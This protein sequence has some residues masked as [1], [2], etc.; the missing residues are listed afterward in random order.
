MLEFRSKSI[1]RT[2]VVGAIVLIAFGFLIDF[3]S[4]FYILT[5]SKSIYA[6]LGGFLIVA[7]FYVIGESGSESIG[8]KDKV[9]DPL[10]KR[11]FRLLSLLIFAALIL[12]AMWFALKYLGLMRI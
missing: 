7:M 2:I 8:G 6:G 5:H 10:Y 11:A 9:T 12:T 3:F 1:L 4:G